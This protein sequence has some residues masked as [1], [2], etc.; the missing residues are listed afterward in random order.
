MT[1]ST[2]IRILFVLVLLSVAFFAGY[3]GKLALNDGTLDSVLAAI[4]SVD[5]PNRDTERQFEHANFKD[6]RF[7]E[8]EFA[9]HPN[10]RFREFLRD[11]TRF[12]S[13]S[14]A[15]SPG[16][17]ITERKPDSLISGI[18]TRELVVDYQAPPL[19]LRSLW[20]RS[21]TGSGKLLVILPA[22]GSS[23]NK[24]LGADNLD[25][26][27]AIGFYA[28]QWGFDVVV[29]DLVSDPGVRAAIN[30]RLTMMGHQIAGV[31]I[32]Q[33]CDTVTWLQREVGYEEIYLY[34][35]RDG[36]RLADIT[37]VLC[38]EP[39]K[40]VLLDAL[41]L[42][43]KVHIWRA[44]VRDQINEPALYQYFGPLLADTSYLDFMLDGGAKRLYLLEP[45]SWE[46]VKPTLAAHF[47]ATPTR[48][49][50]DGLVIMRR[51]KRASITLRDEV[52]AIL[53]H[54]LGGATAFSLTAR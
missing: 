6:L 30:L 7:R 4:R 20:A 35:L 16:T 27:S 24:I 54:D 53:E 17:P 18:E 3:A 14:S 48:N 2:R 49:A 40:L 44:A 33:V 38:P 42:P 26:Q 43:W 51:P 13:V 32:R 9:F 29:P 34:G 15:R 12:D 23:A 47:D 39:F 36:A 31:Q 41:P 10:V 8:P 22:M 19:S 46:N 52:Q 45:E 37:A 50:S 28:V 11:A 21:N 5:F 1:S 25:F